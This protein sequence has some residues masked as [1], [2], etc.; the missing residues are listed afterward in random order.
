MILSV[1]SDPHSGNLLDWAGPRSDFL[2]VLKNAER[3]RKHR[4]KIKPW[5]ATPVSKAATYTLSSA[6]TAG[7]RRPGLQCKMSLTVVTI[8]Q[9]VLSEADFVIAL[10]CGCS[11]SA[12]LLSFAPYGSG[13][14]RSR[15]RTFLLQIVHCL[16][17][18]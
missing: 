18:E 5:L 11:Q 6:K 4:P 9:Y 8:G 1:E 14:G 16:G 2:S 13:P 3:R 10:R 12:K 15:D 7:L 17:W